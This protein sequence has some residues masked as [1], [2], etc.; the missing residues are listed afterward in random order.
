MED[1]HYVQ[2]V[3]KSMI[4]SDERFR[5]TTIFINAFEAKKL[6]AY[7]KIDHVLMNDRLI[8]IIRELPQENT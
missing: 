3:L 7:G 6:C 4:E 1:N 2:K 5:L 8:V